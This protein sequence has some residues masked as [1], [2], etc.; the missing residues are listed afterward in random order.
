VI[1]KRQFAFFG[2]QQ[3]RGR[4][5]L[6]ADRPD[7][8]AHRRRGR[9]RVA[10]VAVRTLIHDLRAAHDGNRRA[11]RPGGAQDRQGGAVDLRALSRCELLGGGWCGDA[12]REDAQ[13]GPE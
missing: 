7:R 2:Q 5:E 6:L 13:Q 9:S 3:H 12:E 8:V 1:G 10:S 4:G 11:W